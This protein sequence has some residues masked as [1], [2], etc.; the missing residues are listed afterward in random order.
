MP[1]DNAGIEAVLIR[2]LPQIAAA[3]TGA[4]VVQWVGWG[5]VAFMILFVIA[6]EVLFPLRD[7]ER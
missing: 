2:L 6:A 7:R 1:Q 3:V 4:A 5:G